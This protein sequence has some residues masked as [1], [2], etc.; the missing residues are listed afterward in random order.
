MC[1]CVYM[2]SSRFMYVCMY[3]CIHLSYITSVY[4]PH[5]DSCVALHPFRLHLL[6]LTL[7][8]LFVTSS[9]V[10]ASLPPLVKTAAVFI[11][12]R[13]RRVTAKWRKRR[14]EKHKELGGARKN[15]GSFFLPM[16]KGVLIRHEKERDKVEAVENG[17]CMSAKSKRERPT[18]GRDTWKEEKV[19]NRK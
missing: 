12:S 13:V 9:S 19:G 15:E 14:Q 6:S 5:S 11:S 7:P 3:L 18:M 4:L 17:R 10:S 16:N 2:Y 8:S 1:A